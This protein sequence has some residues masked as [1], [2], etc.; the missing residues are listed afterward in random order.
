MSKQKQKQWCIVVI[1]THPKVLPVLSVYGPYETEA[2]VNLECE[3][4]KFAH[5]MFGS[6]HIEC[7]VKILE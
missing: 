1:T 7:Y 3:R 2:E 4:K 6:T 5:R